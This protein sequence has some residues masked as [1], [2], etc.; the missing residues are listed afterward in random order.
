VSLLGLV[1]A[2]LIALE[3]V[4]HYRD[5]WKNYRST[6]QY[7]RGQKYLF[8]NRAGDYSVEPLEVAFKAF[9]VNIEYAIK[10]ENEVT[11]SVLSRA[12]SSEAAEPTSPGRS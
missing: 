1:V 5:Q 6:E 12:D 8:Q 11:L 3:G 10:E 9:V 2:L 7:I 4:L